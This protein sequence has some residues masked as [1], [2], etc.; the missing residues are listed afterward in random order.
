[1][2]LSETAEKLVTALQRDG[3][4]VLCFPCVAEETDSTIYE[5]HEAVRELI[6][7]RRA[8][9]SPNVAC[10]VC[11]RLHLVVGLRTGG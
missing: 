8:L 5:A 3:A 7:N 6:L 9:A 11:H 4:R 2:I 10:S 1:M